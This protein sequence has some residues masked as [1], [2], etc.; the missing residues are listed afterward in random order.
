MMM[1]VRELNVVAAMFWKNFLKAWNRR[2]IRSSVACAI[3]VLSEDKDEHM[4]MMVNMS[5]YR[6]GD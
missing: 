1:Q 5:P 2:L 4:T 3:R 6:D